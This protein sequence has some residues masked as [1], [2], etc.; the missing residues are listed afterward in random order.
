MALAIAAL[1]SM[2]IF[3]SLRQQYQLIDRVQGAS[4]TSL[5]LQARSRLLSNVINNTIPAWAEAEDEAM[6][7]AR[8]LLQS[9]VVDTGTRAAAREIQSDFTI[10]PKRM[11][12]VPRSACLS[13]ISAMPCYLLAS[14]GDSSGEAFGTG[15]MP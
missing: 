4:A 8:L 11:M 15:S 14:L 7:V 1:V 13:T 6:V 5:D 2:L 10:R 3:G 9:L 12:L